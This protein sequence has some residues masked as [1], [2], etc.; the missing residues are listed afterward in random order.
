MAEWFLHALGSGLRGR[1]QKR[2]VS[3]LALGVAAVVF[4]LAGHAQPAV[5]EAA[6][7]SLGQP[8][9]TSGVD[10]RISSALAVLQALDANRVDAIWSQASAHF[11]Q[12]VKRSDF[13][14]LLATAH[15]RSGALQNRQWVAAIRGLARQPGAPDAAIVEIRFESSFARL[16]YAVEAVQFRWQ[17]TQWRFNGYRLDMPPAR[18]T[19]EGGQG[20]PPSTN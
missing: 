9:Q 8:A 15:Q 14:K 13:E 6:G 3:G 2:W 4:P 10:Q 12:N 20:Q 5:S 18:A 7:T 17:D 16:P 11:Q 1:D 19:S